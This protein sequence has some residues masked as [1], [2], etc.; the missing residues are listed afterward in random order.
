MGE[1]RTRIADLAHHGWETALEALAGFR[2]NADLRQASSLAFYSLLALIPALLLLTYLLGLIIG[3]SAAA[4]QRVTDYLARMVPDQAERVLQDVAGLTRHPGTAGWLNLLVLA[5]SVS[6]LVSALREIVRGIYKERE[7][8]S[9][10]LV[11]LMDLAGGVASLTALAAL[12]GAGVFL[13]FLNASFLGARTVSPG[14]VLPFAVST[15]LVMGLV[16]FYAPRDARRGH[17]LAGALTTTVLWFLLRPAF[18]WF[19]AVDPTY[20]VAFGSFKS[21]FLIVIW[22][23]V[24][25]ATLLLGV[26]V[27]A[28]CHRGDAVAIKRLMEGRARRG[29]PGHRRLILDA[30]GG[31]AFFREGEPGGEMFYVLSGSVRILKGDREI[32]RIGPGSFLGEM[33]FLLGL[34]RSATAIAAEPC[35]CVVIHARNFAQ[36]LREYP[37]TVRVMLVGMATRLRA[38][39]EKSAGNPTAEDV[40]ALS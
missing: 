8:R 36:L 39:S 25:M 33:T 6:P 14:L 18:T 29:Y 11:K 22:I 34:D 4:H 27:A 10:W 20:G 24:S 1:R 13:H 23:Y 3:S 5:W 32:A 40:A 2:A 21:L 17:L 38:T 7:T 26:E 30:P 16:S 19:L 28:A 12:A 35:Q 31:H 15:A 9:L 37:D